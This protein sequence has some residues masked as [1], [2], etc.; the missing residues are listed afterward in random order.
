MADETK[1]TPKPAKPI[2]YRQVIDSLY[3]TI[4][5]LGQL[6]ITDPTLK[7]YVRKNIINF[8]NATEV[9]NEC[10]EAIREKYG[11][12]TFD[13][14]KRTFVYE[15]E[16]NQELAYQE[17][18]KHLDEP[19]VEEVFM[20]KR[21]AVDEVNGFTVVQ[22]AFLDPIIIETEPPKEEKK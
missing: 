1:E 20:L 16:G 22:S 15:K 18:K 21:K 13:D 8:K 17:L 9:S 6:S 12:P 3:Q 5:Q 2:T 14:N 11:K 19:I 7:S 10:Q 4:V